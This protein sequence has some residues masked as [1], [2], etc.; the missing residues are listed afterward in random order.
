M[1]EAQSLSRRYGDFT[2]VD[3]ISF[4]VDEG[5]IVG[6]L[7]PNGAGKTTTIRMVTG[8]LPPTEGR[9]VVAGHDLFAEPLAARKHLGY[10]PENVALYREMRVREYLAYRARLL[11][12]GKSEAKSAIGA[13]LE[14]CLLSEVEGQIIGTLSKGFRQRVGLATAILHEPRVLMLDEPTVGLDPKQIVA[15]RELIRELGASRTLMLSTHILPEVELLCNRVLIID[16]GRIV[17]Q[18]TPASLRERWRGN[19]TLQV[20]LKDDPVGVEERWSVLPGVVSVR[21][22]AGDSEPGPSA[23]TSRWTLECTP[24]TDLR[25]EVF[26]LA[27]A[28]GW[29]LLGL[30]EDKASLEDIFVRLMAQ[31]T[32]PPAQIP[33]SAHAEVGTV[34]E[35]AP[36]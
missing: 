9:V 1:I 35:G 15:I 27:V 26:R 3:D 30:S 14:R 11:G 36:S 12:M 10:L 25:E 16:R 2:A 29:I 4:S 33:P 32:V 20:V 24:G 31:D 28:Q 13:A 23:A 22:V 19:P 21:R 7:G 8:F 17:D 34:A 6:F 18:G 5:E